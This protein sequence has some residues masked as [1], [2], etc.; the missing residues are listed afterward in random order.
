MRTALA[1]AALVVLIVHGAVFYQQFQNEWS[2]QQKAYFDQAQSRAVNA[3]EKA[4]LGARSPKVEQILVSTFGENRVDRCTT[5]HIAAD[6]PRFKDHFE[7]LKSHPFSA[8]M[9]DAK[10][11]NGEWER[12]HKFNDFGC[13]VCH[14]GQGRGLDQFHAHGADEFWPDPMLGYV[15]QA[16]WRKDFT[17][18]TGNE[19]LEA[20]CAQCHT[21]DNFAG[22]PHLNRGRQLFFKYNCFGCHKIDGL[23]EGTLGPE[24]TEAG[25]KYKVDYLWES[26]VEPRANLATSFMPQF[27]MPWEDVRDLVVFLKSRKG[28]NYNETGL[29][30]YRARLNPRLESPEAAAMVTDASLK[31]PHITGFDLL[32]QH[33]CLAC[34]KLNDKDGGIAPDLSYEGLTRD[35]DWIFA[36][37]KNPRDR[38][39]DSIMPSFRYTDQVFRDMTTYLVS[40]KTPAKF[41]PGA[42][43][44][45]NLCARCHGDKADGMGLTEPYLDPA[46]RNLAKGSFLGTKPRER[47]IRSIENGVPGTSMPDWGKVLN[48]EQI[49]GTLDYIFA[50]FVDDK[51]ARH[52]EHHMPETN[53][54]PNSPESRA[55]GEAT[56]LARCT[57][58]HGK[59]ADGK[60][61][62]SIDISPHPRNLRNAF[63]VHALSDT[64]MLESI[65]YG[66]RGTAMPSWI[67]YGLTQKDAG[68]LINYIRGLTPAQRLA[69]PIRTADTAPRIPPGVSRATSPDS[70]SLSRDREGA[71]PSNHPTQIR[72]G[73]K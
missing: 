33:S 34:H 19:F 48:D 39:P 58:C 8:A 15:K 7:P 2:S 70:A 40:L 38:M 3:A 6:D 66:V 26:I 43:T 62:N 51:N 20:A 72:Q 67:E 14:D 57:G 44:F 45:K 11:P 24:L 31:S 21:E 61:P 5:C 25:K 50:T 69:A 18:L 13:T 64:R 71:V 28:F 52:V 35:S 37:F 65:L 63:F 4:E 41:A 53:P 36:H 73:D 10:K 27:R 22:T 9:G 60:G 54:V 49:N 55:R 1:I 23:S 12:K 47:L 68:D 16:N 17:H 59:K 30:R 46:P 32:D 29:S 42:E 56:F